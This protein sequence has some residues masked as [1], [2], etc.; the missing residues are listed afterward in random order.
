M[1]YDFLTAAFPWIGMGIMVAIF[2]AGIF[3]KGQ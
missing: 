1:L 3:H 2:A